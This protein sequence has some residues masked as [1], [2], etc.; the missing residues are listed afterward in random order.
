MHTPFQCMKWLSGI[1]SGFAGNTPELLIT[2]ILNHAAGTKRDD[3]V[4]TRLA[5]LFHAARVPVEIVACEAA[6]AVGAASLAARSGA[7]A[8]VAAGGDGTISGVA[9]ALAGSNTSLGVLPLGTFNHFAKDLGI[10]LD[11]E[12]AVKTI[13]GGRMKRVDV[14]A[15]NDRIFVNNSSLGVYPDIVWERESLRQRGHRKWEAFA[16]ASARVLRHYRGH[17]VT[18]TAGESTRSVRTPFLFVGNNEYQVEG[19]RLGGRTRLDGGQLVAY[20]APRVHGRELPKMLAMALVGR[21]SKNHSLE[22]FAA[23]DFQIDMRHGGPVRVALD[24]E[25]LLMKTP[26]RYR[27]HPL[28][29]SVLVP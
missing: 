20:L 13:A 26:L 18:I 11:P 19:L 2:V 17:R 28:A 29:L 21:A 3:D 8:V 5:D 23:R 15:V 7:D 14:G 1:G 4:R 25:V 6:D 10:P 27:V 12:L 16:V 24:G 9:A 22:S